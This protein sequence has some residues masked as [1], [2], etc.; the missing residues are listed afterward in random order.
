[1]EIH[2]ILDEKIA[3]LG[4][5]QRP[6]T[7]PQDD[8]PPI[9]PQLRALYNKGEISTL[10][11][12]DPLTPHIKNTDWAEV[13]D[14]LAGEYEGINVSTPTQLHLA[15]RVHAPLDHYLRRYE[16]GWGEDPLATLEFTNEQL[17]R[18][19][20]RKPHDI[21]TGEFVHAYLLAD[22]EE[23]L[24]KI[25]HDFQNKLLNILLQNSLIARLEGKKAIKPPPLPDRTD[26]SPMRIDGI[27]NQL[28]W[29][30]NYYYQQLQALTD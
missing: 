23:A 21:Q 13:G 14:L 26:P 3:N 24:H 4:H 17:Y 25:I 15:L 19:A 11:F 12:P 29:W 18:T 2:H 10:L 28:D 8:A 27:F 22:D 16:H 9:L 20:A 1:A 7:S 30:S 5:I 6:P